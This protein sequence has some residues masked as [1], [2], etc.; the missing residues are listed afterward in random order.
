VGEAVEAAADLEVDELGS[1]EEKEELP[2]PEAVK[3]IADGEEKQVLAA[4]AQAEVDRVD[5]CE[6]NGKFKAVEYHGAGVK[7]GGGRNANSILRKN[8]LYRDED[9]A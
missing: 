4:G 2:A 6:E 7:G 3:E 1:Y 8:W 5:D 9:E